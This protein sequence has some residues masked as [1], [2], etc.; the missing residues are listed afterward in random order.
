M[1]SL[2]PHEMLASLRTRVELDRAHLERA[3]VALAGIDAFGLQ[4]HFERFCDELSAR[5]GWRLGE[6]ETMNTSA[7]VD[8]P[9]G[10]RARIAAD[11]AFDIE[12]YEF[13]RQLL[14][15]RGISRSGLKTAGVGQ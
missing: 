8:V 1:L 12:L 14:D 10:L 4:E 5:F 3:K 2:A 6:P 13:A 9:E 11:N 7:P 15:D